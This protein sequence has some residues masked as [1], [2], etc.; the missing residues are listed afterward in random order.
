MQCA[1]HSSISKVDIYETLLPPIGV[2]EPP[3]GVA[4]PPRDIEISSISTLRPTKLST[5]Q[6]FRPQLTPRPLLMPAR[7]A[8]GVGVKLLDLRCFT[9]KREPRV[10]P[11]KRLQVL[12]RL[13][14]AFPFLSV[15]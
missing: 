12:L 15:Y 9:F 4:E 3:I 14:N 13:G 10:K 8:S 1:E 6:L 7:R 11:L 2:A 5:Q